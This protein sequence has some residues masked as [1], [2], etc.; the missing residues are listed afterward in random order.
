MNSI[1]EMIEI[2]RNSPVVVGL[3]EYGSASS[4]DH[5]IDG[6]YDLI[7]IV[8]MHL[9]DVESLHFYVDDTPIDLNIR[10]IDQIHAMDQADGS[11]TNC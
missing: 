2:L 8:D 10:T 9:T 7:V 1:P 6:D 4:L 5:R 11:T 3:A